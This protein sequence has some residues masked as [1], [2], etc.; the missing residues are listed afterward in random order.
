MLPPRAADPRATHRSGRRERLRPARLPRA[1]HGRCRRT[2]GAARWRRRSWATR[3]RFEHCSILRY[4]ESLFLRGRYLTARDKNA[5]GIGPLLDLSQP[6]RLDAAPRSSILPRSFFQSCACDGKP[7]RA[8]SSATRSKTPPGTPS[9]SSPSSSRASRASRSASRSSRSVRRA[10]AAAVSNDEST[11]M[12][13]IRGIL[14]AFVLVAL[15]MPSNAVAEVFVDLRVGGALHAGRRRRLQRVR[16][17]V[18][19]R[20]GDIE[21]S[22]TGGGRLGKWLDS[23][24]GSAWPPTPR[25]SLPTPT[26]GRGDRRRTDTPLLMLRAPLSRTEEFPHRRL[27]PFLGVGPGIYISEIEAGGGTGTIRST[28]ASTSTPDSSCW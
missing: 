10:A 5:R 11:I 28:S 24:R 2:R 13:R 18:R 1:V 26:T 17:H 15:S 16:S 21:D 4:I 6:P 12:D 22:V 8:P 20:R 9:R 14:V 3:R 23:T 25:T 19:E 7:S 27:Q